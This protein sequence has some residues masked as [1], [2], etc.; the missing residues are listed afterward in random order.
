MSLNLDTTIESLKE[1]IKKEH[2]S[3]EIIILGGIAMEYYGK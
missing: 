1:F 3:L 2:L